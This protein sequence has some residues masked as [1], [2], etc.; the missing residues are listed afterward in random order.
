M[1]SSAEK[2]SDQDGLFNYPEYYY[3]IIRLIHETR[4]RAW[5]DGLLA[6]Y[7]E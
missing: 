2:W 6:Y 1:I 4:D 3:R 5:A 7:N